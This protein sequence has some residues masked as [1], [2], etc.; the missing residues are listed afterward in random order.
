MKPY[1][2]HAVSF[3]RTMPLRSLKN[4]HSSPLEKDIIGDSEWESLASLDARSR[5]PKDPKTAHLFPLPRR[6][7]CCR[8]GFEL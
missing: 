3:G 6:V 2:G 8:P 4:S 7:R 1:V 5:H